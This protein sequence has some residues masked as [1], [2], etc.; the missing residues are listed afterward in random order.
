MGKYKNKKKIFKKFTF[1]K[2]FFL[3]LKKS[4][5]EKKI[6]IHNLN[7]YWR[8]II[9]LKNLSNFCYIPDCLISLGSYKK[10]DPAIFEFKKLRIPVI[11]I[12]ECGDYL[13][14]LT[15]LIPSNS[16]S[17]IVSFFF[18]LVFKYTSLKARFVVFKKKKKIIVGST[19]NLKKKQFFWVNKN[20]LKITKN[21]H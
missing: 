21:R 8:C 12:V 9:F 10:I 3:F 4:Y 19:T 13:K 5:K 16:S 18:F 7:I 14:S 1:L 11:G 17:F 20:K 2:I 15:Y 6:D